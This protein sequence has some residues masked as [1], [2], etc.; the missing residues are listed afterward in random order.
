VDKQQEADERT[1]HLE[2][3]TDAMSN[4]PQLV[5][6][7]VAMQQK[8]PDSTPKLTEL[9]P[10]QLHE[11]TA[12]A[13]ELLYQKWNGTEKFISDEVVPLCEEIIHR[14]RQPGVTGTFRLNGK[15]TVEQYFRSINLSY[16]TVRSWIHRKNRRRA[17]LANPLQAD[18]PKK[19]GG[20]PGK[21]GKPE[22][23]LTL[24]EAKLLANADDGHD[25]IDTIRASGL[26]LPP[27]LQEAIAHIEENYP[28][29]R[30]QEWR[31]HRIADYEP[32]VGA[33]IVVDDERYEILEAPSLK[34][35]GE[36]MLVQIPV[37]PVR[38]T[39]S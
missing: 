1:T 36:L 15:P 35:E 23:E 30:V 27:P 32:W 25:L 16:N 31:S 20:A 37:K 29:D 18:R 4:T 22:H 5:T 24:L 26:T 38:K 11:R 19:S 12:S 7:P 9:D 8:Q 17:L 21:G 39:N 28:R 33:V 14:Y 10:N 13:R 3:T 6:T 34:E 2:E